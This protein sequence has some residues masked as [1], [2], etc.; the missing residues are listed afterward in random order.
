MAT[1]LWPGGGR[2]CRLPTHGPLLRRAGGNGVEVA[3]SRL[4][5]SLQLTEW[6]V[7]ERQVAARHASR[8][9][10]VRELVHR[11]AA[12][13]AE[14]RRARPGRL[15]PL[16]GCSPGLA[17]HFFLPVPRT[18]AAGSVCCSSMVRANSPHVRGAR[19]GTPM[20]KPPFSQSRRREEEEEDF[21]SSSCRVEVEQQQHVFLSALCTPCSPCSGLYHIYTR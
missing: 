9:S 19:M 7:A 6:H 13:P 21:S 16:R 4:H 14:I 11:A 20:E 1:K 17:C 5:L 18:A 15:R 12:C 8:V 10:L 3:H 2:R